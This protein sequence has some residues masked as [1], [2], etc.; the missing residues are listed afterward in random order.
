MD[1]VQQTPDEWNRSFLGSVGRM[2]LDPKRMSGVGEALL[3]PAHIIKKLMDH[4]Y[5]PGTQD[6]EGVK[7]AADAALAI[8][9]SGAPVPR[10]AGS[11]GMFTGVKSKTA[12]LDALE[13]A[14]RLEKEGA[15]TEETIM[16]TGWGKGKDNQW[17]YEL[18][19]S[20]EAKIQYPEGI[21]NYD[22]PVKLP[23]V[24][25]YPAL[26]EAHPE[27]MDT[28]IKGGAPRGGGSFERSTSKWNP[29]AIHVATDDF[30]KHPVINEW[31]RTKQDAGNR[32][33]LFHEGQHNLQY[34]NE[35]A[36][37]ANAGVFEDALRKDPIFREKYR[38][39]IQPRVDELMKMYEK[40]SGFKDYPDWYRR[41][42][43]SNAIQDISRQLYLHNAG[44]LEAELAARRSTMTDKEK[45]ARPWNLEEGTTKSSGFYATQLERVPRSQQNT[46]DLYRIIEMLSKAK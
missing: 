34:I 35:F 42:A 24:L 15:P 11:I 28:A 23:D 21:M 25:D 39:L 2:L 33:V 40:Q 22:K 3:S 30:V 41:A 44:E 37:G 26:Y 13:V 14:K 4:G 10:P 29:S 16:Q 8:G 17:R 27:M 5:N 1:E 38:G 36:G 32:R 7:N 18:P 31:T 19:K 6:I 43:E 9:I 46:E 12:N 45:A 20:S